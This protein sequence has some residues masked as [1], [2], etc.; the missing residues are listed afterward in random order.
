MAE[1]VIAHRDAPI[2]WAAISRCFCALW[3]L[4]LQEYGAE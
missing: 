3:S 1:N 2:V 4:A